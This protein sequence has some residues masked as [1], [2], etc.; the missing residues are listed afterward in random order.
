KE[1]E[2]ATKLAARAERKERFQHFWLDG[3]FDTGIRAEATSIARRRVLVALAEIFRQ[4][5]RAK[6]NEIIE[7]AKKQGLSESEI[8]AVLMDFIRRQVLLVKEDTYQFELSNPSR[9]YMY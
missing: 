9:E 3:I 6:K 7:Q 2:E 1:I 8:E 5:H 4:H